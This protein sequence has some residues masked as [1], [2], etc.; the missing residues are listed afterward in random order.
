MGNTS[1]DFHYKFK[2][3]SPLS[4]D[5]R[6]I[7]EQKEFSLEYNKKIAKDLYE[8]SLS[9]KDES[10]RLKLL[11]KTL[12]YNNVNENAIIDYL[13]ILKKKDRNIFKEAKQLYAPAISKKNFDS[14]FKN[15]LSEGEVCKKINP[16]EQLKN[17]MELILDF[18]VYNINSK[19][20]IF[21]YFSL[22]FSQTKFKSNVDFSFEDNEELYTLFLYEWICSEI[23]IFIGKIFKKINTSKK[24]FQQKLA[25]FCP[26][27]DD[28][29][30]AEKSKT[31]DVKS[32]N[33][34]IFLYSYF[35]RQCEKASKYL[36]FFRKLIYYCLDNWNKESLYIFRY[37]LNEM[38]E[39]IK[40]NKI[41]ID[42]QSK[43]YIELKNY[44]QITQKKMDLQNLVQQEF[45]D[46]I[47]IEG[48]NLKLNIR[49]EVII[50]K[51]YNRYNLNDLLSNMIN[52]P[53]YN[54]KSF[55]LYKYKFINIKYF[56]E[57]NIIRACDKFISR[58]LTY[59]GKSNTIISLLNTIFP[60]YS[61]YESTKFEAW[62][63]S[64]LLNFYK[65]IN[66]YKQHLEVLALT[67]ESNLEINYLFFPDDNENIGI[68]AITFSNVVEN[69]GFFTY[70]FYHESLGHLLLRFLNILTKMNYNSPRNAN[71][72][73]ESG[74]FIESLLFNQRKSEYNIYELLYIIDID[75]YNVDY[76]NFRKKFQ[77]AEHNYKPSQNLINMLK[78]IGIETE[79]N[80]NKI[81]FKKKIQ[82]IDLEY[83]ILI[84]IQVM[85]NM[86]QWFSIL[87]F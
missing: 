29:S 50:L 61:F 36:N 20:A 28:L 80:L 17:M 44:Y 53:D 21:Q 16:I 35:F 82:N 25:E 57:N 71:N 27:D 4:L 52:L 22:N 48:N 47:K 72:E 58:L 40:G 69:L 33:I 8:Q 23:N 83:L 7:E 67:Q 62:L 49:D 11:E 31:E 24:D 37:I 42:I 79:K 77:S 84:I 9:E 64:Y 14:F 46:M 68:D 12:N 73:A 5:K 86:V 76:K 19:H 39:Y 10:E 15:E 45:M 54:E 81:I 66:Y 70:S 3:F 78:D 32:N 75:N 51:D 74:Q 65:K 34:I 13:Q 59:I 1:K 30:I 6:K 18:N 60:G 85:L 87:V 43:E 38:L 2:Q 26:Y 63:P 55:N 41:L 56:N